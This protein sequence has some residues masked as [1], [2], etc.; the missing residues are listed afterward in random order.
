MKKVIPFKIPKSSK[1][2]VRF[3]EDRQPYFYD[4]LH[5]HPEIQLSCILKG[6]GKLIVGDYLGRFKPGDIFLLGRDVPHVFRSDKVYYEADSK[7]ECH[8]LIVFFDTEALGRAF[9]EAEELQEVRS[10]LDKLKGCYQVQ[11]INEPSFRRQVELLKEISGLDKMLAGLALLRVLLL[12]AKLERLNLD[13][14]VQDLSEREGRRMDQVLHFLVEQSHRAIP[15]EE[16]A[17]VANLSREAF[18]RFFKE[19]TRK[20]F[21]AFLNEI[22]VGNACQMLKK[23]DATIA[24]VA[25]SVG[26][27]NLSHF[28]RVF[29]NIMGCSPKVYRRSGREQLPHR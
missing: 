4:K 11:G 27:S 17:A 18:C 25:F 22:R 9:W 6:E 15:L 5:Q 20:T 2:F 8:D 23:E 1:E 12:E 3:Q 16:A 7:Q 19:R 21:T 13:D 14:R 10:F 24:S 29:K 28:N 26:F